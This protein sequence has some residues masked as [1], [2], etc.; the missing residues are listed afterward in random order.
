MADGPRYQRIADLLR[1]EIRGG[2][3]KPGDRLPS[4][5]EL[6]EQMQVSIT[7][8]R[9]AIQVLV[10]ENLVYT[11]TSRGT[12]VRS[13]EVL[14][15][16]VTNHIRPNRPRAAHDIF[17]EI[18]RAAGREPSKQFT[19]RME[20]ASAEVAHWLGIAKDSWVVARTVVQYLDNE[21]WSW[22]VSFY[23]RDLAEATG[24]DCPY[25]IPEGTTRRL[26]DRGH[27][28][29]AHRDSIVAR[30]ATSEE[31]AVLGV[32]PGTFLL[33]HLRI[34]ANHDR[35][36]RVTRHRSTAARNRLTYELGDDSGTEMIRRVLGVPSAPANSHSFGNSLLPGSP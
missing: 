34:G 13:Q 9:N 1:E 2:K 36:T 19:A 25:D 23:P 22:E 18:A 10:A 7:T 14:E 30:P 12:I 11:A 15:S 20:P 35:V 3:W 26:A 5:N 4:H 29:T 21:P 28:E 33:D 31:A 27:A 24:I 6:A 8:A 32:G 16:V 17:E